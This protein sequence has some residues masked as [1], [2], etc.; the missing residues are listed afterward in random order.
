MN[1]LVHLFSTQRGTCC[2]S[3]NTEVQQ[4]DT[5]GGGLVSKLEGSFIDIGRLFEVGEREPSQDYKDGD[6]AE[7]VVK[8]AVV[9]RHILDAPPLDMDDARSCL[10]FSM[11]LEKSEENSTLGIKVQQA[12]KKC[13]IRISHLGEGL[14]QDWNDA[15]PE[16]CVKV[17]DV[18]LEVNGTHGP[19]SVALTEKLRT[20]NSLEI[21]I[22]RSV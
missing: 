1:P 16:K 15:H 9:Q 22:Q 10:Q 14:V 3:M 17:G 18:I 20:E 13:Q 12:H 4:Q 2:C 19:S 5:L 11:F 8:C 6:D 21:I 7:P